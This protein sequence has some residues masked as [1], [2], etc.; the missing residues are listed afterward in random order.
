MTQP[1]RQS[2]SY[3]QR[4]NRQER[5]KEMIRKAKE[6]F[7]ENRDGYA[8]VDNGISMKGDRCKPTHA[9]LT[10]GCGQHS[11]I[12]YYT[13]DATEIVRVCIRRFD[14]RKDNGCGYTDKVPVGYDRIKKKK[15]EEAPAKEE[16]P[17]TNAAA[18]SV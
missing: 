16:A 18:S 2:E 1:K 9:D 5:R 10:G 8:P 6:W 12:R 15:V 7:A 14:S 17:A 4:M 3:T 11:L 13:P